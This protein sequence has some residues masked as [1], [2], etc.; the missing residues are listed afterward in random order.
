MMDKLC[1][2]CERVYDAKRADSKYCSSKCRKV[3]SRNVTDNE[4]SVTKADVTD[5]SVTDIIEMTASD[6]TDK[7]K[8]YFQG[9]PLSEI[10]P[11]KEFL[12][13]ERWMKCKG[14]RWWML[15]G[16]LNR[17]KLPFARKK[18]MEPEAK[19]KTFRELMYTHDVRYGARDKDF[20][21]IGSY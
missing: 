10:D 13:G 17:D 9:R 2:V 19:R 11:E 16:S 12:I 4:I 3:A 5:N 14:L 21:L 8:V 20:N 7:S 1:E 6:V 18:R 15:D